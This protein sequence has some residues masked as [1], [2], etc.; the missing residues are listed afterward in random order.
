MYE[1][2]RKQFLKLLTDSIENTH[3]E[4]QSPTFLVHASPQQSDLIL[5][6]QVVIMQTLYFIIKKM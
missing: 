2:T 3:G 5:K 4:K 1:K 6:N